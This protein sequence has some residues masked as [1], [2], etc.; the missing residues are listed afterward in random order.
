MSKRVRRRLA[1]RGEHVLFNG[2]QIAAALYVATGGLIDLAATCNA[3]R[4][5]GA[6]DGCPLCK[7][8]GKIPS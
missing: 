8:T 3:C 7:G 2:Y 6:F 1:A 5:H 4:A